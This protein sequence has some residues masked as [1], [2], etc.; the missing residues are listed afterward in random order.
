MS[1]APAEPRRSFR[2]LQG[3]VAAV[4]RQGPNWRIVVAEVSGG[5]TSGGGGGEGPGQGVNVIDARTADAAAIPALLREH[6]VARVITVIPAADTVC[7]SIPLPEGDPAEI[8]SA[9]SLLAE[10]E[11][12]ASIPAHRRA[13]GILRP[14]P[15]DAAPLAL[16]VGWPE[17]GGAG[18][19]ADPLESVPEHTRLW[20]PES[21][22]LAALARAR[23]GCRLA[24]YAD[25]NAGSVAL[26]ASGPSR[27]LAR[28][29]RADT[30][31]DDAWRASISD[32]AEQLAAIVNGSLSVPDAAGSAERF[33]HL[34]AP[35]GGPLRLPGVQHDA[36]RTTDDG[37]ALGAILACAGPDS[38]LE[39]L[40]SIRPSAT[41]HGGTVPD[42]IFT[43]LS[44]PV[45]AGA[46]I[47]ASLALVL[48]VPLAVAAARNAALERRAGSLDALRERLE[49]ADREAAFYDLLRARRW[50]MTKLLADVAGAAPV[51][52]R[53]ESIDLSP[54][55]AGPGLL[56]RGTAPSADAVTEFAANLAATRIVTDIATPSIAAEGLGVLFQLQARVVAPLFRAPPAA[57]FAEQTLAQRLYG[58]AASRIRLVD[59]GDAPA[60][61]PA[62]PSRAARREPSASR[63]TRQ[64]DAP[65]PRAAEVPPPLTDE[66][67]A[68]MDRPTVIRE[69]AA[70]RLAATRA[71]PGSADRQRLDDEVAKLKQRLDAF[72]SGGDQ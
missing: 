14:G 39:P 65:S 21:V 61:R 48:L 31:T 12:P 71:A 59:S 63:E 3:R 6:K 69:F 40:L 53:V 46:V 55:Q 16:L 60:P 17:R 24:L 33:L 50:P 70:R 43:W 64:P 68:A 35:A 27:S 72:R 15:A 11:L 26:L 4:H 8:V 7:R 58:E 45:R 5:G 28:I 49:A 18:A 62:E 54:D 34:D 19:A 38:T 20:V 52:I 37:L 42:R 66:A 32:A 1:P 10:A 29:L 36:A 47:A 2:R 30:S 51:G 56:V 23:G 9:L 13:G 44:A 22:A 41:N 67:I 57:D 25:R